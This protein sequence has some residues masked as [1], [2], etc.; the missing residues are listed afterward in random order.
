VTVVRYGTWYGEAAGP[1]ERFAAAVHMAMMTHRPARVCEIGGGANPLLSLA[2]VEQAGVEEYLVTDISEA[3]LAKAPDGYT[4]V[5]ADATRGP[6]AAI[7]RADLVFSQT[8][9][10]H[11]SD[12]GAF[13]RTVFQM[14]GPGG[15][16]MHF[17]PTLYEPV[18]VANKLLPEGLTE[19]LLHRIQPSRQRGGNN[20]KF[21]AFYRWCRGP[22]RGQLARLGSAGFEI[23][24]YMGIFG[25]AYY[26]SVPILD[27]IDAAAARFLAA[28]PLPALTAYAWV[29]LRRPRPPS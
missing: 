8:V 23:E 18:F 27:R 9:A 3:E 28:N 11:V 12:P 14:L 29:T 1:H 13:H 17:F 16:A 6:S 20:E 7:G 2:T 24:E 15:R 4:K 21:P 22:T 26:R 10:E 25:H 5:L 19:R